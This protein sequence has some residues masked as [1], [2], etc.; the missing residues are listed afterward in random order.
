LK[1]SLTTLAVFIFCIAL[2]PGIPATAQQ[3]KDASLPIVPAKIEVQVNSVLVPV[4]VRDGQGRAMGNLAKEDFQVLDKG[5]RRVISGFSVEKRA[6]TGTEVT[7]DTEGVPV[8]GRGEPGASL[9]TSPVTGLQQQA[10]GSRFVVFLLDDMHTSAADMVPVKKAAV[11]ILDEM[12][13]KN[14]FA[15]VNSIFGRV[16]SGVTTD[17]AKLEGAIE[18]IQASRSPYQRTGHECPNLDFY[19]ADRIQNKH[20]RLALESAIDQTLVCARLEPGMRGEAEAM[21]LEAAQQSLALGEQ[22]ARVILIYIRELVRQMGNLPGQ[23]TLVLI[24]PGFFSETPG[25]MNLESQLIETAA[26][27]NVTISTLDARGLYTNASKAE[28]ALNGPARETLERARSDKESLASTEEVMAGLADATGG[29]FF[30][31]SNDIEGGLKRLAAAPEYVYLLELSLDKVKPDGKY[32][33]LDVKVDRKDLKV[34]ARR[35]YF[36]LK[37]E[38][39]SALTTI[40]IPTSPSIQESA[41]PPK[42]EETS[43]PSAVS[44]AIVAPPSAPSPSAVVPEAKNETKESKTHLLTW[45]PPN[46]DAHL[47]SK[48]ATECSRSTV[49]EQAGAR[50]TEFVTNL[51]N[52][53][54]QERIEYRS[55]GNAYQLDYGVGSFDYTATFERSKKGFV[56]QEDLRPE[57]GS[58]TFPAATQDVGLPEMALIFLPSL[59]SIYEMKCEGV[60]EWKGQAAWVVHFR[61]RVDRPSHLV[62]FGVYPALL[63]GRVW[64]AQDSGEVMHMEIGLMREIPEVNVKDWY[65]SI[66][67]AAVRFRTRDAQVWLPQSANAYGDFAVRRTIISH[68]FSNFQL[69]SVQTDEVIGNAQKSP[70]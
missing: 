39:A 47:P 19:H 18:K 13:G 43:R 22:D 60:T 16:D 28:E 5:K 3:A 30:H 36:A 50:A 26:R 57:K 56:L 21:V 51:Q 69:F 15:S 70:R 14:D 49:L 66:D 54:A 8:V 59:Q 4:V 68:I 7:G 53:T 62:S 34:Q 27:A 9:E 20:D 31:N 6:A 41:V 63:K 11:K 42:S 67:Y 55:M 25:A 65:L 45:D 37:P 44:D 64:I 23:R 1:A 35:G 46:V 38:I 10:T 24:S 48:S 29:T 2:L 12:Q 58:Q 17:R 32:H 40:P 61:Q 52:F 33:L